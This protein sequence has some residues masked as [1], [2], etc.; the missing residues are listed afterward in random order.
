MSDSSS[1][2]ESDSDSDS[3]FDILPGQTVLDKFDDYKIDLDQ[4]KKQTELV[5]IDFST[6]FM[7]TFGLFQ[8][9]LKRNEISDRTLNL[10]KACIF[11][12]PANYTVWYFRRVILFELSKDLNEEINFISR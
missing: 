5:N 11:L 7:I 9:A 2:Y 1:A 8:E 12:N 10:T 3:L 6:K 4:L